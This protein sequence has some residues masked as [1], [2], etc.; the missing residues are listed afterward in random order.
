MTDEV[1]TYGVVQIRHVNPTARLPR[2]FDMN[3]QRFSFIVEQICVRNGLYC[4]LK[5]I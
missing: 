1:H 2:A 5:A 3:Y 4:F